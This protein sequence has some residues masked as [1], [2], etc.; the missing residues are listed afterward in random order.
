M[1][2]T[3]IAAGVFVWIVCGVIDY[4]LSFAY[5]QRGYPSLAAE[6]YWTDLTRCAAMAIFGPFSLFATFILGI[7]GYGF[8]W[9]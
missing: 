2:N 9:R 7:R 8:K 6:L 1:N 3:L 5:F 4:G